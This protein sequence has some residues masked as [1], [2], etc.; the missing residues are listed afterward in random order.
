MSIVRR[1]MWNITRNKTSRFTKQLLKKAST[2]VD[3]Y[4]DFSYEFEKNGE[5]HLLQ[6]LS[7]LNFS[8]IF[9]VGCNV[10]SWAKMAQK[11]F[12]DAKI[13][14]FEISRST[15]GTLDHNLTH[16][17]FF[18][19]NFGLSNIAGEVEYKD[20]G[21]NSGVNTILTSTSYH[22][23]NFRPEKLTA[24]VT[25]GDSFCKSNNI[26]YID[27]LKIDVEGAEY[28]VLDGFKEMISNGKIRCIQ[29][30]YGYASG[31]AKCLM[32][33]FF[34]FFE[35]KGYIVGKLWAN[36][37]DFSGFSYRLNNFRSGPNFVAV[38]SSDTKLIE[39]LRRKNR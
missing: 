7:D 36:G 11:Y 9:D 19:N 24:R 18:K 17:N 33:D 39:R 35:D 32:K 25:T 30:E 6:T 13:Y 38:R 22:D 14:C 28:L 29:F 34:S 20:Y 23:G 21:A 1:I 2:F 31:D 37:I 4:Y 15:F 12:S 10:G 5:M 3:Y 8:V 16:E 26:G 27:F